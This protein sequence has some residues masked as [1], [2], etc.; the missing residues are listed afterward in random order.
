M[1]R[2]GP[3]LFA[4][5][6]SYLA[7]AA[8]GANATPNIGEGYGASAVTDREGT[9][10][11]VSYSRASGSDQINYC[12]IPHG[13]E[14]CAS[15]KSL[16]NPCNNYA[17]YAATNPD[18]DPPKVLI[19]PFGDVI[20][21]THGV[22]GAAPGGGEAARDT[23]Y[24]YQSTDDGEHF[25]TGM[26]F[27]RRA[28]TATSSNAAWNTWS[29]SIFDPAQRRIV[30]VFSVKDN[31]AASSSL[32][33][34]YRG[35]VTVQGAPLGIVATDSLARLTDDADTRNRDGGGDHPTIVQRGAGQFV[36]AWT[37]PDGRIALRQFD[38]P[39]DTTQTLINDASKWTPITGPSEVN[40]DQP[41]LV[42]GPLGTFLMY[43][44]TPNPAADLRDKTWRI[45]RLEGSTLGAATAIP[46]LD[47]SVGDGR[48][49]NSTWVP[50][51]TDGRANLVQDQANG[52]LH[53]VKGLSTSS[54]PPWNHVQ[55]MTSDDG[56]GW[57]VNALLPRPA[58]LIRDFG[59][60][61]R[62]DQYGVASDLDPWLGVATGAQGFGGMTGW[63]WQAAQF[64]FTYPFGGVKLPGTTPPAPV[65]PDPG[66][67]GGS[68]GGGGG[69]TTTTPSDGGGGGGGP[70]PAPAPTPPASVED[71]RCRILQM[72]ALDV[73]ADAC[74]KVDGTAF[75]ASG[76]VHVNGMDIAGASIRFDPTKLKVTS[77]GPVNISVGKADPIKLF[78]GTIDWS[79]PKGNTFG[80]GDID[81][82]KLGSTVFGFKFVGSADVKLV[83]G[84]VEIA[85]NVGLPKLLGGVTA[86]LVL[87][88]DNIASLHVRELKF[89]FSL[90]KLG[91]LDIADASLGFSPEGDYWAGKAR[92]S[93][94]PGMSLA[95][96]IEFRDGAL[97]KLAGAFNPPAPGFP[98]DAFSV[99]YL[100]EIRA[101]LSQ[102]PLTLSGGLTIGAGPPLSKTG[103]ERVVRVDGDLTVT[104]PENA[105]VT[106]RGDGV[107]SV[108]GIPIARAYL[109]YVTDGHISAG[110]GVKYSF[111]PFSA[112]GGFDGWFY[113]EAFNLEGHAEVCAGVCLGGRVVFS[114]KG[115]AAC[116]HALVADV[117]AGITWGS[118]LALSLIN[119]GYLLSHLDVMPVGCDVGDYRAVAARAAQATGER[120][121]TFKDGLPSGVVGVIGRDGPP[122]VALVGPDGTRVEP[123][124]N[125]PVN[126]AKAFAF[127]SLKDR[128]TWFDVKAPKAGVWKLVPAA[129]STPITE[130]RQADGLA[131][132]KVTATVTKGKGRQR[133]LTYKIAPIPGQTVAFAE[134]R[135]GSIGA[136]IA[137][138]KNKTKGAVAFTPTAGPGGR[139]TI[140]AQVAQKGIPRRTIVV[141]HYVAP[142]PPRPATPRLRIRR[143]GTKL[144]V[145]WRKDP[146]SRRF[147]VSATLS[148]GRVL[149][150]A[151]KVPK[152]TIPAV[153]KTTSAT[154]VV[155]GED[156]NG[157]G[158]PRATARVKAVKAKHKAKRA[159]AAAWTA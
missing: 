39:A 74:F 22:C 137:D 139:R 37:D 128:L 57:S 119:P 121:V 106:I 141:A 89:A 85:G 40:A 145:S 103:P 65:D 59:G 31:T 50:D 130:L 20:V 25:D 69:G 60:T 34:K 54:S 43:R 73:L 131:D 78:S 62:R 55:Y 159:T 64:G 45:R 112:E 111:G 77:T 136:A 154:I 58:D 94:P 125:V 110:G 68:G 126:T 155:R 107:G 63:S 157:V 146:Q 115:F 143:A 66:N 82:G 53:F 71:K 36:V 149:T 104:L 114:S 42:S 79:V 150:L 28:W 151:P 10:H 129:G 32:D 144:M 75:V 105:P 52:R 6:L 86:D 99:A 123:Q 148:D 33:L 1:R 30:S 14:T 26:A 117:G 16:P 35:G 48:G 24:I 29:A 4:M 21:M 134:Q 91:P 113:D 133:V 87:R 23:N 51:N 97:T 98:L 41:H 49:Y 46:A 95:A 27:S 96:E 84:A 44:Y 83:R 38:Q 81:V 8:P 92:F 147:V 88:S 158:G 17:E 19:S 142:A 13:T 127:Q 90:A 9:T 156:R 93:V 72:G 11:L 76:G 138:V 70:A 109:Q 5:A 80:L 153:A 140:I 12:R 102:N 2:L 132:P 15:T 118:D 116:A 18:V 7:L 152:V 120:S 47:L 3:A 67:P 124:P 61:G 108:M 101:S 122:Q 100:T 135:S 56:V